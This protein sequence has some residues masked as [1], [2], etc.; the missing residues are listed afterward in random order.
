MIM[1]YNGYANWD[2]WNTGLWL[3]NDEWS[4]NEAI[5]IAR[6]SYDV[7]DMAKKLKNEVPGI[8]EMC[9]CSDQID[10]NEVDWD[11]IAAT[12]TEFG[13]WNNEEDE[14]V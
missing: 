9:G 4:Y 3:S 13:Y 8:L 11:E 12:Y 2:T 14:D 1:T 5:R 10:F 6:H 7:W